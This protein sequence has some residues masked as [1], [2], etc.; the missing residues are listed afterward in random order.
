MRARTSGAWSGEDGPSRHA[1][2]VVSSQFAGP[3]FEPL[4]WEFGVILMRLWTLGNRQPLSPAGPTVCTGI[5]SDEFSENP[6]VFTSGW[7]E[8]SRLFRWSTLKEQ[9]KRP[10]ENGCH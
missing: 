7:Q 10:H 6:P 8:R 1:S 2:R 9:V 5:G 3:V 4:V